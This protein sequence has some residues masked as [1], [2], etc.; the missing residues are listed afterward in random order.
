MP[1]IYLSP[2]EALWLSNTLYKLDTEELGFE[3]LERRVSLVTDDQHAPT[4]QA[5]LDHALRTCQVDGVIEVDD[6]AN[7]SLSFNDD[8]EDEEF[9]EVDGAYVMAWVWIPREDVKELY[10]LDSDDEKDD[11]HG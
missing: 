5:F 6:N 11:P 2:R 8:E 3:A 1:Y 9:G 10:L 4:R 7:V